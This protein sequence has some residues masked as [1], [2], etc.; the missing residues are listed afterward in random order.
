MVTCCA[1]NCGKSSTKLKVDDVKGWHT[2]PYKP[3]DKLLRQKWIV[4]MKRDPPYP[5]KKEDFVICGSHFT[6]E[7]FERDLRY[8]L[9]GGK[10]TYKLLPTA[11]PTIFTFDKKEGETDKNEKKRTFSEKR[12][13]KRRKSVTVEEA[14]SSYST[15][16][17]PAKK[18]GR[19]NKSEDISCDEIHSIDDKI[20]SPPT[21]VS[22]G[23]QTDESSLQQEYASYSVPIDSSTEE[24][25][26]N[27]SD[28]CFD[29]M[30]HSIESEINYDE[31]NAMTLKKYVLVEWEKLKSLFSRC[32]VCGQKAVLKDVSRKGSMVKVCGSCT[33]HEY[34]WTSQSFKNRIPEGNMEMS[35]G[36]LLS[37]MTYTGFRR[38]MDIIG[39]S[40]ISERRF[41]E[42]QKFYLFPAIDHVYQKQKK[43]II[44]RSQNKHL[45]VAGDARFD[46]PGYSAKYGTYSIMNTESKEILDFFI[47]H[48]SNAGSSQGMEL[49]AFKNILYQLT[50][51]DSLSFSTLTTD[52]HTQI[53]KYMATNH[54]DIDHQFDIWHFAKSVKKLLSA[55]AKY[56]RF[57][58]LGQWSKSVINHLWWCSATC[59]EDE[60]ILKE[61]WLSIL[62]HVSNVHS[63]IGNE[64]FYACEHGELDT[65][66]VRTKKWLPSGTLVHDALS[67]IITDA[68]VLSDL[69]YL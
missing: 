4:A 16:T 51:A 67:E 65:E 23:T 52:R 46:S 36:I 9:M 11:V 28:T 45:S 64:K 17:R 20:Y 29:E 62:Q 61:K 14:C 68:K 26:E 13:D 58:E 43:D 60:V 63:W 42:I 21:L 3:E 33:A 1:I 40:I 66:E 48:V 34:E 2:V 22:V 5:V 49:Y 18:R 44:Q 37:G 24:E 25:S 30:Y 47:A 19:P 59:Q 35:A 12:K 50:Q 57:R 53:R 54:T 56:V 32:L 10:K 38:A 31:D 27:D 7:C 6:Y 55:K 39:V 15:P 69:P 8:E 41:Y